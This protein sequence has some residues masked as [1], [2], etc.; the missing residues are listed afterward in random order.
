MLVDVEYLFL[1]ESFGLEIWHTC[2]QHREGLMKKNSW[3]ESN[4]SPLGRVSKLVVVKFFLTTPYVGSFLI[5]F[6]CKSFGLEICHTYYQHKYG[7]MTKK[8]VKK[9]IQSLEDYQSW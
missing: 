5:S 2:Y 4:F 1:N 8:F 6:L 7:L 3:Q 9:E